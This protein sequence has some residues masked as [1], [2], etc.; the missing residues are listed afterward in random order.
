M[1]S[2]PMISL[3]SYLHQS[4]TVFTLV[5]R[6]FQENLLNPLFD[7]VLEDECFDPG[8]GANEDECFDP[9]DD[10]DEI[11]D[12]LDIDTS[13]DFEDDYYDSE[14][15][16]IY[17]EILHFEG[18]NIPPDSEEFLDHDPRS[19]EDE[20]DKDDLKYIVKDCPD[21]KDSRARGFFHRSLD[22]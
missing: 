2:S 6:S 7:D 9:G 16:I 3:I 20:P 1:K 11:D 17:L 18:L 21:Y 22:P 19:L 14:G 15:D 4:M 10:I 8:D 13:S 12:F 5:L